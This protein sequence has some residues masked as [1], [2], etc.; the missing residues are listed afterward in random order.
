[1]RFTVGWWL[2][3]S[4]GV[5]LL[6]LPLLSPIP[7]APPWSLPV[8]ELHPALSGDGSLLVCEL[9]DGSG[10]RVTDLRAGATRVVPARGANT[11][12][13]S[14]DGRW[15]AFASEASDLVPVDRD[16]CAGIFLDDLAR[17]TRL[18]IPSPVQTPGRCTSFWPALSSDGR[19]LCY[20]TWGTSE[21][22]RRF[23]VRA[24][25][26]SAV[27]PVPG[28]AYG[29][30]TFSPD[31]GQLAVAST[32]GKRTDLYL[33][34]LWR[35]ARLYPTA[36]RLLTAGADGPSA[37]PVLAEGLCVFS[38]RARNLVPDDRNP[39]WD[40]FARDT[41]TGKVA[42]LTEGANDSSFEPSV[43]RDGRWV[44][45]SSY[46]T[47]LAPCDGDGV[48]QVFLHDRVSHQTRCLSR[49]LSGSSY[50]P[51]ISRDG[52]RVVFVTRGADGSQALRFWTRQGDRLEAVE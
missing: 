7:E 44:A 6:S 29:R 1:M 12:S 18:R 47:N 28:L 32:A 50:N 35:A 25:G 45:F 11:P 2:V 41:R 5:V 42:L 40:I 38:S 10:I 31:G 33:L 16:A 19:I 22:V 4:V 43:S 26:D 14:G 20:S 34:D 27:V 49:G 8:R 51:V 13:L 24:R 48:C 21:E 37:G 30:A 17:G 39:G 15:L 52:S 36:A 3:V 46:A 9:W 23:V